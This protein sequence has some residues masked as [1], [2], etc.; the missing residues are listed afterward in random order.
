MYFALTHF[1][2]HSSLPGNGTQIT[3]YHRKRTDHLEIWFS[4]QTEGGASLHKCTPPEFPKFSAQPQNSSTPRK[5]I[6]TVTN[7]H[8]TPKFIS[9]NWVSVILPFEVHLQ[10]VP[11]CGRQQIARNMKSVIT[12]HRFPNGSH[13][14]RRQSPYKIE[15]EGPH[16]RLLLARPLKI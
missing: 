10:K 12:V 3:R 15:G 9:R 14:T 5:H 1:P 11:G 16:M 8:V 13:S 4:R 2:T 7:S 6:I